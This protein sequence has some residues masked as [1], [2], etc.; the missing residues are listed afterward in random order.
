MLR[1]YF[2]NAER[3]D[4]LVEVLLAVTVLSSVLYIAWATVNRASQIGL[5]AQKRITMVNAVKEQA[6][7]IKA[8]YSTTA[9]TMTNVTAS[10]IPADPCSTKD[11]QGVPNPS[12]AYYIDGSANLAAGLKQ[13]GSAERDRI[14][15]QRI[16]EAGYY[17]YYVR[18][19]WQSLGGAQQDEN[20]HLIVR[21]NK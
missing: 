6:E 9:P 13:V 12:H 1:K 20:T 21:L 18:A 16:D 14:W 17:D 19:C 7:I 10:D 15:I 4:S 5:N 11:P 8:K 3:G 2:P